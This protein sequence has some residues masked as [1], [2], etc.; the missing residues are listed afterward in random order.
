MKNLKI[1]ALV[2]L[3]SITFSCSSDS[4]SLLDDEGNPNQYF[5]PPV[6]IQGTWKIQ[7]APNGYFQFKQDDF[8]LLTPYT[9]YKAILEQTASTG[10]TAK[11]DETINDTDYNFVITAGTSTGTYKF[12]KVNAN[13]IQWSS[14]GMTPVY[15]YK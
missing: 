4:N 9:S 11:V 1:F 7:N 2:M 15:L 3:A 13:T 14:N 10:Q 12:K 5:H 6:W 8:I